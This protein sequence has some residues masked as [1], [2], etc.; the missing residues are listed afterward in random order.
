M[1][2]G[3]CWWDVSERKTIEPDNRLERV[4]LELL[5]PIKKLSHNGKKILSGVSPVELLQQGFE[6]TIPSNKREGPKSSIPHIIEDKLMQFKPSF[7]FTKGHDI[8]GIKTQILCASSNIAILGGTLVV[9]A[10]DAQVK[11]QNMER[12][13]TFATLE[14]VNSCHSLCFASPQPAASI[15]KHWTTKLVI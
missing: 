1:V 15:V 10:S 6:I 13:I 5:V 14:V 2:F 4:S 3:S 11:P 9:P 8:A 12:A 7:L